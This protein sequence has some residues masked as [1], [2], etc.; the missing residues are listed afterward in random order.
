MAAFHS[1]PHHHGL[2]VPSHHH[3]HTPDSNE[4]ANR[5]HFDREANKYDDKPLA[6]EV[7]R[8]QVEFILKAYPFNEDST[9]VM[10]YACGTGEDSI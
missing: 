10:D 6:I 3:P 1:H 5:L 9:V 4:E 8:Q 2:D 7:A